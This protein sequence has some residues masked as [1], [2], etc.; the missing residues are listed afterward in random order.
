MCD[1]GRC[2]CVTAMQSCLSDDQHDA[3]TQIPHRVVDLPLY[4]RTVPSQS[5]SLLLLGN[6]GYEQIKMKHGKEEAFHGP[7]EEALISPSWLE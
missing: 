5:G 1:K 2:V 6:N 3:G 4:S 7:S